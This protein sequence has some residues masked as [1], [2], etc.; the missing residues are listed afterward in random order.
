MCEHEHGYTAL[1]FAG[2][3]GN[4]EV[5]N[6]LLLAGAKV[7]ATNTVNR[8]PAQMAAFVGNHGCVTTINNFVPKIEIE[9]YT[10]PQGMQKT[11]YLP[12]YLSDNFHKFVMQV[13][14]HPVR[15]ALNLQ[16]AVGLVDHLDEVKKV[17][18]LMSEKEMKRKEVNEVMSFKFH[19]FGYVVGEI[20]RISKNK[21]DNET[22]EK[23][24]DVFEVFTRKMLKPAKDGNLDFM[25]SFLK[26]CIREYSFRDCTLFKQIVT[27]VTRD[28]SP[29]VLSIITTAINGQRAFT[30]VVSVCNTCGEEKPAKKCSKCKV[31]QYCDRNCQ[32]LHWFVH[33]KSCARLEHNG[34]LLESGQKVTASDISSE[35]QNMLVNN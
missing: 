30:E 22:E 28:D 14:V 2:L 1:H 34:Q 10:V 21:K 15:V 29:S 8:T 20:A 24:S 9:Y 17:L 25:D 18:V 4:V 32:R 23:K 31:V 16:S 3:S 6:L 26:E 13:N 11:P 5:C 19:Y 33:K 35:L 12:M 27:S 7:N